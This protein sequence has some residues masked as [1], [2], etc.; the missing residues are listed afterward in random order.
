[1]AKSSQH[2]LPRKP[3]VHI[4]YNVHKGDAQEIKELPFV[5]GVLGDFSG[6]SEKPLVPLKD[7]KF[8]NIGRENFDK[9]MAQI[10]PRL[11][12]KVD[13]LL[14]ES[15][16][17]FEVTLKFTS[18]EDFEP[19]RVVEQV[20]QLKKLL[21]TR[22]RLRDLMAKADNSVALEGL[23]EQV[24]QNQEQIK[25]LASELEQQAPRKGTGE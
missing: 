18:M 10:E 1:M 12:F 11:Q 3:R 24:L 13:N 9:V 15:G 14:D 5:V 25:S 2:D 16:Q 6:N 23:L 19:G 22:N 21:E 7:R 20:P 4:T 8:V 17:E